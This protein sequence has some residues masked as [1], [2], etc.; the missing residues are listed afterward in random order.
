[1]ARAKVEGRREA[2]MAAAVR[3]FASGGLEA[4]TSAI[5]KRA[6]VAEGTLFTYFRTKDELVNAVYRV[7]KAE[8]ADAMMAGFPR[9][10]TVRVRMR[11]VWDRYVAWGIANP[12]KQMVLRRMEVWEG[13]TKESHKAGAAP[14]AEIKAMADEAEEQGIMKDQPRRFVAAAMGS[15][16]EMVM[17]LAR[18]DPKRA[19][20]YREA[21]FQMLWA[22]V[23]VEK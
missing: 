4:A 15:L 2:I 12:E 14:F 10:R 23:A 6:G 1:M 19:D 16:A 13:L 18:D 17:V 7:L 9:R 22:G 8:V 3:V 21:G 5:S 11:H 20:V